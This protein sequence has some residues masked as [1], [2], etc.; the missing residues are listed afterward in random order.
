MSEVER[1]RA[2][3]DKSADT[4]ERTPETQRQ[5]VFDLY[6]VSKIGVTTGLM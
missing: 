5:A 3:A 4:E 1:A 2:V 6:A